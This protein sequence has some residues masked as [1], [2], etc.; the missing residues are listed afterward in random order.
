M[1]SGFRFPARRI[2]INLAPADLP[3]EGGKFDLPIAIGILIAS[4]QLRC[5]NI[6]D[7]EFAG[8][9]ALSGELRK[10]RAILPQAL[11]CKNANKSLIVSSGNVYESSLVTGL[12]VYPAKH[13]LDVCAH[14]NNNKLLAPAQLICEPTI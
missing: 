9:L 13:L 11:A 3:K 8:E 2:I 14:L 12:I 6:N 4:G 7:Y 1:N 10:V 5:D